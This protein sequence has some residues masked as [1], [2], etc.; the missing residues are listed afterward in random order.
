MDPLVKSK[1]DSFL[2]SLLSSSLLASLVL[3]L[4]SSSALNNCCYDINVF[5]SVAI[6]LSKG[7]THWSLALVGAP[8]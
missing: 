8:C 2:F 1:S 7:A 6:A 3:Y 4:I 5:L